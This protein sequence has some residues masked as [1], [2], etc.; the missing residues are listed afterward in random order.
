LSARRLDP[1]TGCEYNLEVPALRPD[2]SCAGRLV[3]LV[4]DSETVT[5]K[6]F[7]TWKQQKVSV[8]ENFKLCCKEVQADRTVDDLADIL[9]D[10][11]TSHS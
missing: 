3:E 11:I 6:R 4:Q 7:E 10:E 2:D 1:L 8:E 5:K 9:A